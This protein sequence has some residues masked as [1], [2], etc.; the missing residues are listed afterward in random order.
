MK[1]NVVRTS[2][3]YKCFVDN[4]KAC[5][6]LNKRLRQYTDQK[7]LYKFQ[8]HEEGIFHFQEKDYPFVLA[9]L[10]TFGCQD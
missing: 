3:G 6:N 2:S 1:D 10:K 8:E 7:V 9:T 5:N 4:H